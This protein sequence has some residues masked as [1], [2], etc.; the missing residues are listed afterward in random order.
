ME[1]VK[2]TDA[3]QSFMHLYFFNLFNIILE[4]HTKMMYN[5]YKYTFEV[6]SYEKNC[7]SSEQR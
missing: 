7:N 5:M 1:Y 3:Y 4:N 2:N 6:F